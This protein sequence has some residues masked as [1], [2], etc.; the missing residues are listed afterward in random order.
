LMKRPSAS[1]S[2]RFQPGWRG[3]RWF[4]R[5]ERIRARI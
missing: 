3:K 4:N 1:L 2:V 5:A